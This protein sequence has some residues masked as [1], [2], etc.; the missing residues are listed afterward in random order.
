MSA[1]RTNS[2]PI[3]LE[4]ARE[5][6]ARSLFEYFRLLDQPL[7]EHERKNAERHID[8]EN[9]VPGIIVRDPAADGRA[10]GRGHDDRNAVDREGLRALPQRERIGQHR[11]LAGRHAAAAK[12]LQDAEHD[13]RGKAGGKPAQQRRY[14]EQRDADHVETLAADHVRQPAADRQN[15]RVGDEIGGDDPGAFVDADG[16]TA[17]DVAQRNIG[18][19]GVENHHEGGDRNDDGDQPGTAIARGRA[20]LRPAA[21]RWSLISS[22]RSPRPTCRDRATRRAARRTRS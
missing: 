1:I 16:E 18:D 8:E 13:Q 4:P 6:L 2:D 7:D 9:P 19:G 22:V 3:D 12:S 20:A 11:L 21:A 17:G 15:D 5:P 10:D 14:R